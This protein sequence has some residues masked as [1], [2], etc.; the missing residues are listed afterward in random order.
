MT[1]TKEQLIIE[2]EELQSRLVETEE[3]LAAIRG[4][5]VDAII[6]PGREGDQVYT[7]SSADTP[8]RNFIEH[9]NEGAITLS[10]E[11][12][13]VYCNRR[14]AV[15]VN[16]PVE[17][18][19]GS[20][21]N[22][23]IA[24]GD[25]SGFDKFLARKKPDANNVLAVSLVSS[26]YLKLSFHGLPAYLHGDNCMLV[27]T[28]VTEIKMEQEKLRELSLLLEQKL[29]LIQQLR[30]QLIEKKID[31]EVEI[32]KLKGTNKKLAEKITRNKQVEADLRLKLKKK[33]RTI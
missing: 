23:F 19:I 25:R 4:G 10:R 13:V 27:A 14:F 29:G 8:Y 31:S 3:A 6:V 1:R 18:V 11:G 21:F 24:P 26:L 17:Q 28:D 2:N 15:L 5:E 33:K 7:L 22:R 32:K 30:M 16:E 12:L 20:Y 9:M